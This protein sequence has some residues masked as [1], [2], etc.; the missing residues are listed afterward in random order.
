MITSGEAMASG[1]DVPT[2]ATFASD[3]AFSAK[4]YA[5]FL[6]TESNV[7]AAI[8]YGHQDKDC[9]SRWLEAELEPVFGGDLRRVAFEGYIQA[10]RRL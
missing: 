1:F 10:L 2:T 8:E 3:W 9:V 4:A 6:M 7:V 5:A